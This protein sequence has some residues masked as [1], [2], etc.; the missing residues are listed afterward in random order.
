MAQW[1]IFSLCRIILTAAADVTDK[2]EEKIQETTADEKTEERKWIGYIPDR[3]WED[4]YKR[5]L[6]DR[7][8][9]FAPFAA[10]TGHEAAIKET[11]RLTD[12]KAELS[13]EMIAELNDQ[14]NICLLYTSSDA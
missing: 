12:R 4:V 2:Y 14:I 5:Q 8:A 3:E 10:L 1:M 6:H 9:Q 13:D 7:A 11:A